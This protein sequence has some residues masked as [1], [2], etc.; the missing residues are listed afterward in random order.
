MT[1]K[2]RIFHAILFEIGA[3]SVATLAVVISG[4]NG[5][6]ALA[7][8]LV[9]AIMAMVWNMIFNSIFDYFVTGK[10]EQRSIRLR[11]VHT[12]L[13]EGILILATMPVIAL[14]MNLTLWQ[15]FWADIGLTTLIVIYTFI[16]NWS[17]DMLRA[18]W[19]LKKWANA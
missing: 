3:I 5:Q 1:V 17:Y 19:L 7:V 2:E 6:S 18:K 15:A 4:K 9:M 8:S 10:R 12:L 14:M 13:F 16:F 11:I